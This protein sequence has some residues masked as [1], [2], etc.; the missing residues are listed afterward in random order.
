MNAGF[1]CSVVP[2]LERGACNAIAAAWIGGDG[3][4]TP[5]HD[6]SAGHDERAR[7]S[8]SSLVIPGLDPG[9]PK[10]SV[11]S[12]GRVTPGHDESTGDGEG[13]GHDAG[14]GHDESPRPGSNLRA[15]G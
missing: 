5:G 12:D 6:E 15:A 4:V 1:R 9:I 2:E 13:A 11:A 8:R 3:R 14:L 10:A 7:P